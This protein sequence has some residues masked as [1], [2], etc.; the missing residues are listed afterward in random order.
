MAAITGPAEEHAAGRL[1]QPLADNN[2]LSLVLEPGLA[3]VGRERSLHRLFE[4][5]E[6]R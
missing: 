3:G 1:H 5:Q 4:L 2:A 6:Q